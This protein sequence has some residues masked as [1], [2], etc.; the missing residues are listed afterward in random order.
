[1]PPESASPHR[2]SCRETKEQATL[3]LV[4][5]AVSG[6]EALPLKGRWCQEGSGGR[7][8]S[9]R[10]MTVTERTGL[11][12][13]SLSEWPRPIADRAT[14]GGQKR[15]AHIC[16]HMPPC[17]QLHAG[18]VSWEGGG[19]FE[20]QQRLSSHLKGGIPTT[21]EWSAPKVKSINHL[22]SHREF[23]KALK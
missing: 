13:S 19:E 18:C 17:C 9:H 8:A 23:L 6:S 4:P 22:L 20:G 21:K 12:L 5:R 1:M 14:S 10:Q 2:G 7:L 15:D 11:S 3:P 16:T